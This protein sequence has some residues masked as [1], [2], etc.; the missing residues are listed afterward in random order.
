MSLL[1][2]TLQLLAQDTRKASFGVSKFEAL[3]F[4][5]AAHHRTIL[6]S[7]LPLVGEDIY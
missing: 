4:S 3:H 1:W 7:L 2:G 5:G 6:I